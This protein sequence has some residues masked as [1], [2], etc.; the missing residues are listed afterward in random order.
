MAT[1]RTHVFD[2]C[3]RS[4]K[5]NGQWSATNSQKLCNQMNRG[6]TQ[7]TVH[8]RLPPQ[9]A[10]NLPLIRVPK[11]GNFHRRLL[12]KIAEIATEN[13]QNRQLAKFRLI[14]LIF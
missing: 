6:S 13:R 10:T 14:G 2:T 7:S 4:I 9:L 8:M 3:L 5:K 11:S 1:G 12:E